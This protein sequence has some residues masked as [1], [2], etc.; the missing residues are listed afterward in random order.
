[1]K[2]SPLPIAGAYHIVPEKLG[3]NRG[4][5]ARLFCNERF[6]E[7]GL[8]IEWAQMNLSR[9]AQKGTLRGLHFQRP[10]FSE[11][12]LVRA[13]SGKV[14][15][16]LVDLREG[17]KTFGAHCGV[18]LDSD[19]LE[20]LYIPQ[21]CAHGFQTLTDDVELHYMHSAPY[22]LEHEGGIRFDDPTLSI[23]WPLG[24]TETSP[25]DRAL[26]LFSDIKPITL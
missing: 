21:G 20:A 1:M 18:I 13:V 6:A 17:S 3:D 5:F 14:F 23:R 24:V 12:K 4:A 2:I 19:Q 15:D 25:R 10:P 22:A 8:N 9:S 16:V 26:P 7:Q 11:V